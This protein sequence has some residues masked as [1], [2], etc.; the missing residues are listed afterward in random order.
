VLEE[1]TGNATDAVR[2]Y[3]GKNRN[4]RVPNRRTFLSVDH[5]FREMGTFHGMRWDVG[6][7]VSVRNVQLESRS[8]KSL[9]DSLTE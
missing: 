6:G 1:C 7:P 8:S 3:R 2:R 4:R 9:K 5:R